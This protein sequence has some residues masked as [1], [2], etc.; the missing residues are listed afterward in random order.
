LAKDRSNRQISKK[1]RE[2][3]RRKRVL[4]VIVAAPENATERSEL[5]GR[6]KQARRSWKDGTISAFLP[7]VQ[8]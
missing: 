4:A 5:A 8:Y 2:A 6:I 1:R 7:G 3:S